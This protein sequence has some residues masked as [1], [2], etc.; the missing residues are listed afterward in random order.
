VFETFFFRNVGAKS[1][2]KEYE[3][4]YK[5]VIVKQPEDG[6]QS[7]NIAQNEKAAMEV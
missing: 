3:Q 7:R 5:K 6:T 1:Q 2:I 4:S